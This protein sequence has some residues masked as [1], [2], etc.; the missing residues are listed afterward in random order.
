[1]YQFFAFDEKG[2]NAVCG[3]Y[4]DGVNGQDVG[5]GL[6]QGREE[7]ENPFQ[8]FLASAV[9]SHRFPYEM[10]KHQEADGSGPEVALQGAVDEGQ[11]P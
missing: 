8:Y 5:R 7:F 1:M 2:Q 11:F 10:V 4:H 3:T 6:D 9:N